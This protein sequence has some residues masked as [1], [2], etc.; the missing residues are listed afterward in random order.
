[1]SSIT[2]TSIFKT[3][4]LGAQLPAPQAAAM[5]TVNRIQKRQHIFSALLT[6]VVVLL[7]C[8]GQ[9]FSLSSTCPQSNQHSL[10]SPA[11]AG[12]ERQAQLQHKPCDM[13]AQMLAHQPPLLLNLGLAALLLFLLMLDWLCTLKPASRYTTPT[14]APPRR[15]HLL[16]CTFLE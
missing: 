6:V 10:L 13:S 7:V 16:L 4:T 9:Q 1:M 12:T 5:L 11:D 14:L 3:T 2:L 8:W 15:R